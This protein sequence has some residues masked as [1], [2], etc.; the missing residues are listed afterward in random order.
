MVTHAGY[1]LM[2]LLV[3]D[4]REDTNIYTQQSIRPSTPS[5]TTTGFCL[6]CSIRQRRLR[7]HMAK[8]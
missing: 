7:E 6:N 5:R 3:K 2:R 8:R 4:F 1:T